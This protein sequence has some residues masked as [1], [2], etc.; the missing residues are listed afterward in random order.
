MLFVENRA[1]R[2]IDTITGIGWFRD[3][4]VVANFALQANIAYEAV[5]GLRIHA[6]HISRVRISIR[7]PICHIEKKH[8]FMAS[9]DRFAFSCHQPSPSP[10]ESGLESFCLRVLRS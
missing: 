3:L 7:I 1:F 9:L 8:K 10:V 5:P 2:H 4:D 6:R